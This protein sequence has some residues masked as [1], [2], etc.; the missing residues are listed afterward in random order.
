MS[1][2]IN[3]ALERNI[4]DIIIE[5]PV[6]QNFLDRYNIG[7]APCALGTCKLKDVISIHNLDATQEMAL[8]KEIFATMFPGQVYDIPRVGSDN[9]RQGN[10]LSPA[11]QTMVKEHTFIKQVL[12]KIPVIV[13]NI[14]INDDSNLNQILRITDFIKNYADK[15]HHAK[16]ENILFAYFDSSLDIVQV[17]LHDHANGRS[18]VKNIIEG[19]QQKSAETIKENLLNYQALLTEHIYKEDNILY[20]WMES[21]MDMRTIGELY[22]R[23]AT[24]DVEYKEIRE[25][26]EQ[27]AAT[28]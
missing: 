3:T 9:H 13:E 6:V 23:C 8:L 16:E 7:C 18:F 20:P 17:M 27:F 28:L 26:F 4:K 2:Q 25:E 10:K 12:A 15:Y 11:L 22:S 21:N 14:D 1:T 5:F 19:V 24:V